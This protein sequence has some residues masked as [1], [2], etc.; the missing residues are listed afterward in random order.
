MFK[1]KF[2]GSL[3][4]LVAAFQVALADWQ[5]DYAKAL[6]TAKSQNKRV[7]LD[8][9]GSDWCGPCIQL[10]KTVFSTSE[11]LAYADKNLIL[12]E[13]DYPKRKKQSAELV[14]QNQKLE[15]EYGIDEK[16]YPTLVLLDPSGKKLREFTGYDG[17]T[18]KDLIAW[19]EGKK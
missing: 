16:G 8:F 15:K 13:V 7:L 11:F 6:Q 2:F 19:V 12:V 5:T 18:T 17:E 1:R 10:K 3:L 9:T 4:L 14:K